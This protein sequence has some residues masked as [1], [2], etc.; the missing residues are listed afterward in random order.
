MLLYQLRLITDFTEDRMFIKNLLFFLVFLSVN[1]SAQN[2]K[3]VVPEKDNAVSEGRIYSLIIGISNYKHLPKLSYADRDALAF[4]EFLQNK[5]DV[6]ETQIFCLLNDAAT[7]IQIFDHLYTIASQVKENDRFIFY[8]SGHGDWES[9]ISD[10]SLLLLSKAPKENYLRY[11]DQFINCQMLNAFLRKLSESKVNTVLIADACRSG[12]L[13]GGKSGTEATVLQL[14]QHWNNDIRI[15]SCMPDELSYENEKWGGGRGVFS[16]YLTLGLAGY[17]KSVTTELVDISVGD[18]RRFLEQ[19]VSR[20]TEG[21]QNPVV[22]GDSRIVLARVSNQN[23]DLAFKG[24]TAGKAGPLTARGNH[25]Y[26]EHYLSLKKQFSEQLE[27]NFLAVP[28]NS[29]AFATFRQMMKILPDSILEKERKILLDRIESNFNKYVQ[30][31]YNEVAFPFDELRTLSAE[32]SVAI[33]LTEKQPFIAQRFYSNKLFLDAC[34]LVYNGIHS[35]RKT[36]TGNELN[37]AI[38]LLEEAI[39]INP[40]EPFLYRTLGD[41]YLPLDPEK[42]IAAF[43]KYV[44]LLPNDPLAY[45]AMGIAFYS[46]KQ[47]EQAMLQFNEA[48]SKDGGNSKFYYNLALCYKAMNKPEKAREMFL[49]AQALGQPKDLNEY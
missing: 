2:P 25:N 11:Q 28:Y 39:K 43:N 31:Y 49:K 13:A 14:K 33:D 9:K 20:E 18:L 24:V 5:L 40:Y 12:N 45:N 35:V 48:I 36:V 42:S 44:Q 27:R 46:M 30:H 26:G 1:A 23:S 41:C 7:S 21:R 8:F 37:R 47:Y 32:A 19:N 4:K 17:A 22:E 16:Y 3:G 10:N 15:L 29:S 6:P 38:T 34:M